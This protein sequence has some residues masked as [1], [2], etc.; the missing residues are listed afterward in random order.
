MTLMM[1]EDTSKETVYLR[2]KLV[3]E[4]ESIKNMVETFS[5]SMHEEKKFF[6][7]EVDSL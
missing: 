7:K 5:V 3:V 4:E 2:S 6:K 1:N